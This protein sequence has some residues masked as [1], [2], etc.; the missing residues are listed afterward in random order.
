[1]N[2]LQEL[3]PTNGRKSFYG[4]AKILENETMYILVSYNTNIATC[5]KKSKKFIINPDESLLSKT[6]LSHIRAFQEWN[7]LKPQTKKELLNNN[8]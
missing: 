8:Q 1:M 5:F 3:K 7:G 2:N 6:T 4:K